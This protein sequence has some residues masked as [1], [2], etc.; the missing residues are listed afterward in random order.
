[1]DPCG[2]AELGG[3][4]GPGLGCEGCPVARPGADGL[5]LEAKME[6]GLVFVTSCCFAESRFISG[7]WGRGR[8]KTRFL[9]EYGLGM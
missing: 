8:C 4:Q 1:M 6:G 5:M 7:T 9:S 3:Q 2:G